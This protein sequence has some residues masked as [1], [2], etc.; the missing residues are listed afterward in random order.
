MTTGHTTIT[1]E[2]APD[3][4]LVATDLCDSSDPWLRDSADGIVAGATTPE[5]KALRIFDYVRDHVRFGLA[6]SRSTASQTLRRGYGECGNKTNA[7]VALLRAVGI[8]ARFH[9]VEARAEVLHH[10]IAGFVYRGMPAAA[11]HFWCECYLDGR[12]VSCECLLDRPLYDG[13]LAEQLITR[14]QIPSI[15]WD[16]RRDLVLLGPWIRADLGHLT[17]YDDAIRALQ[18]RDEGMPPLWLERIIAP[19]FYPFSLRSSEALRRRAGPRP[20]AFS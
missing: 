4:Y 10:L 6:F 14:E 17:S 15:D 8:P 18:G 11:S 2:E 16:G 3:A 20:S 13:M 12:W 7:Q 9:W 5:A 1:L 19:V